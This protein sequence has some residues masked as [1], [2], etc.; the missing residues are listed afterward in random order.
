MGILIVLAPGMS[1]RQ[2]I[3]FLTFLFLAMGLGIGWLGLRATNRLHE[4]I[5]TRHRRVSEAELRALAAQAVFEKQVCEWKN[6]LLRGDDSRDFDHYWSGF[7]SQEEECRDLVKDLLG[8]L[9]EESG[10]IGLAERFL[11]EHEQMGENYREA[12]KLFR[13]GGSDGRQAAVRLVRGQDRKPAELFDAIVEI[14]AGERATMQASMD[15]LKIRNTVATAVGTSA[16]SVLAF[17]VLTVAINRWVNRPI[18]SVIAQAGN[19]SEGHF[20]TVEASSSSSDIVS[21]QRALNTMTV[22]LKEGY[23]RL[24]EANRDL[25]AARDEALES[26]RQKS[27]FLANVSHEMRTP[28]N[29]VIGMTELLLQTPLSEEQTTMAATVRSSGKTLLTVIN[30][31]LDF[32]KIEANRIELQQE[33]FEV[34]DLV[35]EAML[36]AATRAAER[37]VGLG[38][39]IEDAVPPMVVGDPMRL[40]QVLTN[41]LINA[42]KFTERGEISVWVSRLECEGPG[43]RLK[44]EVCDT[45]IGIAADK[46]EVIFEAFR[47]ADGSTT[48][49]HGGTG[50]GLAI[51]KR[52]VGLMDGTIRAESREGAGSRFTFDVILAEVGE[53]PERR[54]KPFDLDGKRIMVADD[55]RINRLAL[56][57]RI[58]AWGGRVETAD[59]G[60]AVLR[61]LG[62]AGWNYDLVI[63]DY[64]MPD[65]SGPELAEALRSRPETREAP[66]VLL[67]SVSERLELARRRT[68]PFAAVATKPVGARGLC[69]VFQKVFAG[70]RCGSAGKESGS[71]RWR[72][73]SEDPDEPARLLVAEDDPLNRMYTG[74]LL[75][76][77]GIPHHM[78][79]NGKQ[80]V[81]EAG[82]GCYDVILMDCSMPVM[83][84]FEAARRI[85][86]REGGGSP[87]VIIGLTAHALNGARERCL[88][89]GMDDYISKPVEPEDLCVMLRS[90]LAKTAER[91]SPLL[92]SP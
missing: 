54:G 26:S 65:V 92:P 22:R 47:Q 57:T 43:V 32:S 53:T 74:L 17:L 48:R 78:V 19:I 83:D 21:L 84:G 12:L 8:R 71:V 24:E 68:E 34:E 72:A 23:E 75:R 62:D 81:E 27:E 63:A 86:E 4:E 40:K 44:F 52:L 6:V 9:P 3:L 85:R 31:I 46:L 33:C 11:S 35:E 80:A 64:R 59:S 67:A 55:H 10:A 66:M 28:L 18:G 77:A 70:R 49:A 15:V 16:A 13:A 14:L 76:R 69:E 90:W 41:L 87:P 5:L 39:V 50:L 1:L 61:A 91:E 58:E 2:R 37:D 38:S 42:V 89:A 30:D 88:E 79:E 20:S 36:V 73:A 25:E 7:L 29:G 51:C 82:K 45:G 60:A 56:A